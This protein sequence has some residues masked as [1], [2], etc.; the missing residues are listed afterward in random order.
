MNYFIQNSLSLFNNNPLRSIKQ[1]NTFFKNIANRSIVKQP[2]KLLKI[3]WHHFCCLYNV[4]F[5]FGLLPL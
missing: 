2:D 4:N 5:T 1:N 3:V